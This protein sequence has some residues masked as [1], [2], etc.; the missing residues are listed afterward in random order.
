MWRFSGFLLFTFLLSFFNLRIAFE[1]N[2]SIFSNQ[3]ADPPFYTAD[4]IWVDSVFNSLTPDE[5]IAQLLMVQAYSDRTYEHEKYISEL[6]QNYKIGGLIFMQ[7]SPTKQV[8][9]IN[10]YQSISK[11]PLLISMDAEW[12][13]SMRLDSTVLYPRQMMIGAIQNDRLIYE[14]GI[15]FAR[16]LKRVG[17]HVNFAPVCDVNNNPDNP[18]INE[19]SFGEDKF[20]VAQKSYQYMKGMQ[21]NGVMATGKHFPGHGDTDVD[22]HISLPVI[23]HNISRLD[24]IELFPFRYL[25]KK[26]ISGIM[27]GHLFVP[28]IDPEHN[29]PATLS[30]L[31]VN[32]LLKEEMEFKGLVFTDALNM[33]GI[34]NYYKPGESD[35]KALLAGNDILLFPN[36][37]DLVIN[38]IKKAVDEELIT[39]EEID[40]RC[41]KVLMAKYW[42]GLNDFE[43]IATENLYEDL[44]NSDARLM[45]QK[46]IESSL[47]LVTNNN[48]IV[49]LKN[50]DTLR[51]ATISFGNSKLS[52]FQNR[53]KYYTKTD[54]YIYSEAI[55]KYGYEGL[56][57]E[58]LKYNLV[59]AGVHNTYYSSAK[60]YGISD[61]TIKFIDDISGQNN[62][63]L[64]VFANP[65]SLA[66]FKNADKCVA[67]I[68]SY[69]DWEITNDFSAQLIFGGIPAQGRLPVTPDKRFPVGSGYNTEKIRLKYTR[70]PEEAGVDS[71]WLYKIDSVMNDAIVAEAFPGGQI[72]AARHGI[73]F[74][75]KSFG[76]HTYSKDLPVTDFDLYDL[77]SLTKVVGTTPALMKLYD[78][79]KYELNDS[80]SK[81]VKNIENC[82]KSGFKFFDI[83]TH[84]AGFKSWI[85]FYKET[86]KNEAVRLQYYSNGF[87]EEFSIQVAENMFLLNSFKDSIYEQIRKSD[88]NPYGRYVYSDL[89]FYLF[90]LFIE[91]VTNQSFPDYLNN[92]FYSSIGA[93]TFCFNPLQ[94]FDKNKIV[95]TENDKLFR[96]QLLHGYVH[97]QGASMLGGISGHAG[98]FA[99]ANDV[100]KMMQMY[101]DGG[102]YG[103]VEYIKSETIEMFTKYQFDSTINRRG[104]AWDK[105]CPGDTTKGLGSGSSSHLAYGHSGYTGTM[106]WADPYY[107]MIYVFNSNRVYPDAENWKIIKMNV[108]TIIEEIFYQAILSND[109]SITNPNKK[110]NGNN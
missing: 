71:K 103:G 6:I 86:V 2:K 31:A 35:V 66:Y 97:D 1:D 9:L 17:V 43:P 105:P 36:D 33:G 69:N 85:P 92:E 22:S 44:N 60:R 12:S 10:K 16:Q 57:K 95:P 28:A 56:I 39:Q 88:K 79:N 49:P 67:V 77:A 70:V 26:G 110:A 46:L 18:V 4:S 5:R 109:K 7:G 45:Q 65:Y 101:L 30:P 108:R 34:T 14:M 99:S 58:L 25:I 13:V 42:A 59:I 90:P 68:V 102:E 107:D 83:L 98:L 52:S 73:V 87:S 37:V 80:L 104:L 100:A 63:I 84:R 48:S 32:K 72:V 81:Y 76:Y 53:L 47:T 74:Y 41:K 96:R 93:W 61:E 21:D 15:E 82:D 8:I 78:E 50:L 64:D 19:R 29:T 23:N 3:T 27:V 89:G 94:R 106:V 62:V 54:D 38:E 51:I 75:Q 24:S 11:V 20:N 91:S 55:K 40:L